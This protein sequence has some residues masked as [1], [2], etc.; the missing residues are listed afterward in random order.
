MLN[1]HC[2][3]VAGHTNPEQEHLGFGGIPFV[4]DFKMNIFLLQFE[5]P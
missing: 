2:E 4:K 1:S 3:Q 5:V